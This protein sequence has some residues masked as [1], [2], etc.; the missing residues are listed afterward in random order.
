[1]VV[2]QKGRGVAEVP[3]LCCKTEKT[4]LSSRGCVACAAGGRW[5]C[6]G[7]VF[8]ADG[9]AEFQWYC[10][11]KQV[12][13]RSHG[14]PAGGERGRS[15]MVLLLKEVVDDE[16]LQSSRRRVAVDVQAQVCALGISSRST[17]L[18]DLK[19][20]GPR[21]TARGCLQRICNSGFV[22]EM[23]EK[24]RVIYAIWGVK[25][26]HGREGFVVSLRYT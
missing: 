21:S 3:W 12:I 9:V 1:M 14:A 25:Y 20:A 8:A 6:R 24:R 16:V 22:S 23:P 17:H 2:Q 15:H 10:Y 11:R 19:A 7:S 13:M 26:E 18:T 5:L 4:L